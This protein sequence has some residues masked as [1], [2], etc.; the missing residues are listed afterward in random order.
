MKNG[1][2]FTLIAIRLGINA[3]NKPVEKRLKPKQLRIELDF[4]GENWFGSNVTFEPRESDF[5]YYEEQ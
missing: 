5:R 4:H 2:L 1:F 3:G